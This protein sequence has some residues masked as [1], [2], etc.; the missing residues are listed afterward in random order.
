MIGLT[1]K[2]YLMVL[3][4]LLLGIVPASIP[5]AQ[6]KSNLPSREQAALKAFHL[7][8][9]RGYYRHNFEVATTVQKDSVTVLFR[10][11]NSKV[12]VSSGRLST[13]DLFKVTFTAAKTSVAVLD[14]GIASRNLDA[15]YTKQKDE[16][17]AQ[18]VIAA[19]AYKWKNRKMENEFAVDISEIPKGYVVTLTYIPYTPDAITWVT[20]TKTLKVIE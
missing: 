2:V 18:A 12:T 6:S 10:R 17:R 13:K 19:C 9:G 7:L 20:L 14:K 16:T 4:S 3:V 5:A 1:R 11:P 15:R 8:A